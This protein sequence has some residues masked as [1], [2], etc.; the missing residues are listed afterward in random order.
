MGV[1][2][3][4]LRP[5]PAAQ[6]CSAGGHFLVWPLQPLHL[7]LLALF[8][9]PPNSMLAGAPF[10]DHK[11]LSSLER[12]MGPGTVPYRGKEHGWKVN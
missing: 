11:L 5:P 4:H 3:L 12:L 7:P 8:F 2:G 10:L 6:G 9:L 1:G